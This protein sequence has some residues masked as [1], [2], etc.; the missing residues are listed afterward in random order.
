MCTYAIDS[1]CCLVILIVSRVQLQDN[2]GSKFVKPEVLKQ[3]YEPVIAAP[4]DTPTIEKPRF[5]IDDTF[6]TFAMGFQ[7]GTYRGETVLSAADR[8]E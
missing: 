1:L 6:D 2:A 7:V 4:R 3:L 8:A 5:P